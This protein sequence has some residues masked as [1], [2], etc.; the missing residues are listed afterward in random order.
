MYGMY[1]DVGHSSLFPLNV[2]MSVP[3]HALFFP[4]QH[5]DMLVRCFGCG[6]QYDAMPMLW[7]YFKYLKCKISICKWASNSHELQIHRMLKYHLCSCNSEQMTLQC[8]LEIF[9]THRPH[10][11]PQWSSSILILILCCH[12][13]FGDGVYIYASLSV[14][15]TESVRRH[16]L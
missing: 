7:P 1:I 3:F 11:G 13:I 9:S 4:S 14:N 5:R 12:S 6:R 10:L 15:N 8:W 2:P 16:I